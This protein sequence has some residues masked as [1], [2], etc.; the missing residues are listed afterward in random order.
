MFPNKTGIEFS[1]ESLYVCPIKSLKEVEIF[2]SE[3]ATK[4]ILTQCFDSKQS[5]LPGVSSNFDLLFDQASPQFP[6]FIRSRM[7][8]VA[9]NKKP[10]VRTNV[11]SR[12]SPSVNWINFEL[13][14]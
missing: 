5:W 7:A 2:L 12:I 14:A 13:T 1:K 6:I 8:G 3:T 9:H 4:P 10:E 11:A